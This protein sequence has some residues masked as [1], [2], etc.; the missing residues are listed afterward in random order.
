MKREKFTGNAQF[1]RETLETSWGCQGSQGLV[2]DQHG[3]L[4]P[5]LVHPKSNSWLL[6]TGHFGT[7]FHFSYGLLNG[8]KQLWPVSNANSA[9]APRTVGVN[10]F[11]RTQELI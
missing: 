11:D 9:K 2:L 1:L 4:G 3:P 8:A 10:V 5:P 7:L 6:L